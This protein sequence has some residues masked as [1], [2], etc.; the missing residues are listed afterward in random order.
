MPED[1]VL[2]FTE[3]N[4]DALIGAIDEAVTSTPVFDIHT[5][6]SPPEFG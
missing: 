5:H 2:T 3:H 6:L 1:T 4:N